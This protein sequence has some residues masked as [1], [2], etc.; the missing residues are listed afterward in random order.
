MNRN[1]RILQ[2]VMWGAFGLVFLGLIYWQLIGANAILARDDNP[3]RVIAEQRIRRGQILTAN[4][5][6]LAQTLT[7]ENGLT[8]RRYPYPNL[9]SVTGYYS[10]RYGAGGLESTFDHLLRGED[11]QSELDRLLHRPPVGQ[12]IT[13]TIQL[14][15]QIAAD[16]ALAQANVT[17]AALVMNAQS[18]EVLVMAGRPTFDPNTLDE[19]WDAL[20]ADPS[21]PLLNR[22][23]QG[24]FPLG[25]L[26]R[27]VGMI[28]LFEAGATIPPEPLT[29]P[30]PELLA[31]LGGLGLSA[32]A[33]QL[34]FDRPLPVN[35]PSSA[36]RIPTDLP[37]KAE[38]IAATP[39][40]VALMGAAL[41]TAGAP[42]T[43]TLISPVSSSAQPTR[44]LGIDTAAWV[45]GTLTEF[46]ALASPEVT[47]SEPLSWYVG[48]QPTNPP[49][50]TVV[51][52]TTPQANRRAA[53]EIAR[54]TLKAITI[55]QQEE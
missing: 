9:A 14:P 48:L 20:V 55:P 46:E 40:H 15:A 2:N 32:T 8:Q 17:G 25:E 24:V 27:V 37:N 35:L 54:A 31:P 45:S 6:A 36:G 44:L 34:Q 28:G 33:H 19:Q 30:L 53:A 50:V 18:G 52:V 29:A 26:V 5:V 23:T 1:I 41:L 10:V 49:L 38:E 42:P 51:V 13:V 21:A 16:T 12:N 3:R 43:P 7:D 47:G 22:A 39:L 11:R 4:G